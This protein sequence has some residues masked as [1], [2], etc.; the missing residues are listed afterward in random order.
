MEKYG[1]LKTEVEEPKKEEVSLKDLLK[2]QRKKDRDKVL[3]DTS[4]DRVP[5]PGIY[6]GN[7]SR[8]DGV[9]KS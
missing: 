4:K 5:G 7:S 2:K 6:P 8:G 1:V 3:A 9:K